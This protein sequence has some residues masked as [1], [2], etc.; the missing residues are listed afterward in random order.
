MTASTILA[1]SRTIDALLAEDGHAIAYRPSFRRIADSA[2]SAILLGRIW[3]W[4]KQKGG[5]SFYKFKEPCDHKLYVEG[6]S[7]TEE[8]GFSRSEFDTAIKKIS[9]K[10]TRGMKKAEAM[11]WKDENGEMRPPQY[12]VLSWT[13]SSRVTWYWVN[14]LLFQGYVLMAANPSLGKAEIRLYLETLQSYFT[15]ETRDF[16][17]TFIQK[18]SNIKTPIKEEPPAAP[19]TP[20]EEAKR[21]LSA[22]GVILNGTDLAELI[23]CVEQDPMEWLN[24]AIEEAKKRKK[25]FWKYIHKI[26]RNK[27]AEHDIV[28]E[29][30]KVLREKQSDYDHQLEEEFAQRRALVFGEEN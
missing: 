10:V 26:I 12:I 21:K 14:E 11:D 25:P 30:E 18:D 7:W 15:C 8:L 22:I 24:Y 16:S 9:T 6:D 5:K 20:L 3:H 23:A 17:D 13:D 28:E 1:A 27:R 2:L 19:D 29:A 4:W